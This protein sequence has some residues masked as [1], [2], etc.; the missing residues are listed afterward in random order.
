[1]MRR[2]VLHTFIFFV[3]S[4][5]SLNVDAQEIPS[6][7]VPLPEDV[8]ITLSLRN[9]DINDALKFFAIK[10]GFNIVPTRKVTGRVTLNV[11]NVPVRDVFDIMLRSN[12]L[13]YDRHGVIY[14][15]MTEG[16]YK[17]RYGKN[18]S[19]TRT[20]KIFRLKYAVP[21]QVFNVLD[22]LKSEIGR[23]LAQPES[24]A[25]MLIDTPDKIA[26]AEK[27]IEALEQKNTL[28]VFR[29]KYARAKDVEDQLKS[30]LD[31]KKVGSVKS[32][33]RTNQVVV[34]TL[35][36]RMK[37][38]EELITSLD[39]K[40]KGVLIDVKILK[41]KLTNQR[42]EGVQWEGLFNLAKQYGMTYLGSTPFAVM[43]AGVTNP[44][45]V[46]RGEWQTA[47]NNQIGSY[48]FSG[49]TNSLNAST[50]SVFGKNMH[51]GMV[52]TRR[53][54]DLLVNFLQTI[55]KTKILASPSISVIN[56]QEAKIHVGERQAYVTTTTTVGTTSTTTSEEVTYVD[57]G[58]RLSVIPTINDDGYV[59]MKVKP[60]ISSILGYVISS[61]NNRIPIID[62]NVAETTVIAKDGA[63]V[64]IGGLG[65][66]EKTESTEQFPFL[67]NIPGLGV[68]FRNSTKGTVRVELVVMLTPVI[69]EGDKFINLKENQKFQVKGAKRFDVFRPETPGS[70]NEQGQ[71]AEESQS[72][73]AGLPSKGFRLYDGSMFKQESMPA[74]GTQPSTPV[75]SPLPLVVPGKLLVKGSKSYE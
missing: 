22:T 65:R 41:I 19:D 15:V 69:F 67:G 55:G 7:L 51:I 45:F 4:A 2:W 33:E 20:V 29:L 71:V 62:T 66:E 58:V 32:D 23:L 70:A 38:I 43:N 12:N 47:L 53:D 72:L 5:S 39:R 9:I 37:N 57:T 34:Q 63:T 17:E 13:A 60:E 40:T 54:F 68:L 10:S 18:F 50:K 14:N 36:E 46:T 49:T 3:L 61:S 42:D 52:G 24:G 31:L 28:K 30:Q 35:P 73:D 75:G 1:M 59:T 27:A 25:V 16:E 26:E 8:Q 56:N 44:P 48:P 74:V 11:E 21:E 6:S 64:I